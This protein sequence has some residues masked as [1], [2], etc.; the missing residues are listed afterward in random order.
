MARKPA[1]YQRIRLWNHALKI[2]KKNVKRNNRMGSQV[3]IV[4]LLQTIGIFSIFF[5]VPRDSSKYFLIKTSPNFKQNWNQNDLFKVL[6]KLT[7]HCSRKTSDNYNHINK[8]MKKRMHFFKNG[9][10][11]ACS[12]FSIKQKQYLFN[13]LSHF[14]YCS[15]LLMLVLLY[16]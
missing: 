7:H 4:Y 15:S 12:F 10:C 9:M 11:N 6:F 2:Q 8:K 13:H 16:D 1:K 14:L 3:S 5:S